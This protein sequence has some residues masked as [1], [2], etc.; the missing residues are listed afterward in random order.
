M[1]SYGTVIQQGNFTSTGAAVTIPLRS[2][3][4]WMDVYNITVAA[5]SQTTAIGVQY[6]WIRGFPQG[7][8]LEYKKSNAA[9]AANLT[10]YA[11]TGGFTYVDSSANLPGVLNSTITAISNANPPV[12]TNSG[13]NGLSAGNVVRIINVAGAQ[14][15]GGYDFTVGYG[16][17][18]TT[19]FSLDYAPQIVAGTTGSWRVIPYPSLFYPRRR[20][21]T[22]ITSSGSSSV[23]VTSVTHGFTV[24][25]E[26]RFYVGAA[27]GI[28]TAVNT[29]TSVNSFTVNI[30]SSAFTSFSFPLTA[31]VPFDPAV[32]VPVGEDT[33]A[34]L[35]AGVNIL[36]DA[37]YNTGVIG[38]SLAAGANSPAG[39]NNDQIYWIAGKSWNVN[40]TI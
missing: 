40:N 26:V 12:V 27:F 33:G 17:L 8:M 36:G 14:Q 22:S 25:Q 35:T 34:A 23:V 37:T 20:Y 13:T 38:L 3:V 1:S 7:A 15:F 2:D 18:S 19:T 9:S 28:I 29:S 11:T 4:D 5:A 21:I 24:G 10:A 39:Q 31:A 6:K 16:T 32:V 30:D